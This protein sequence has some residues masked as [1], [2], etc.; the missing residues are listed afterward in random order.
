MRLKD[1]QKNYT[2]GNVI[3]VRVSDEDLDWLKKN[4]VSPS[5]LFSEALKEL[6]PEVEKQKK[7][8]EGLRRLASS[9]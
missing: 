9:R 7:T 6:K 4:N 8:E 2:K 5:L 1:V 3:T